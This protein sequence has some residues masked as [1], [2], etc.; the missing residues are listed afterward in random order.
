MGSGFSGGFGNMPGGGTFKM[1]SNMNGM[2]I[3]PN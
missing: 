2:G 3:D 1:S